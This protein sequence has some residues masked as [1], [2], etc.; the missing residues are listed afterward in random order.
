V[1][2]ALRA[3]VKLTFLQLQE[4][5]STPNACYRSYLP[6]LSIAALRCDVEGGMLS[7][8]W[9]D[10]PKQIATFP[11]INLIRQSRLIKWMKK[12]VL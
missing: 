4:Q 3:L 8:Y 12:L 10:F 6:P 9:G 2:R 11:Y 7:S 1:G 5:V